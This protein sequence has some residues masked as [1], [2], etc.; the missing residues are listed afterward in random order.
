MSQTATSRVIGGRYRVEELLGAGGTASVYRA[1]DDSLGVYRALKMLH[2]DARRRGLDQR[3]ETE[4]RTMA[5]VHHPNILTIYDVG[6]E[7]GSL[8]I[9]TE[10]ASRGSL[11]DRVQRLGPLPP[12]LACACAVAIVD[13][14]DAAHRHGI[15]H[16]DVKPQNVLVTERG[17]VKLMDF[18]IAHVPDAATFGMTV[19][20]TR[21][22]TLAYMPPEQRVDPRRV[23]ARSDLY[24]AGA[25]LCVLLT[26]RNPAD[27][28]SLDAHD[29]LLDGVPKVIRDVIVRATRYRAVDRYA[30]AA[31]MRMALVAARDSLPADPAGAITLTTPLPEPTLATHAAATHAGTSATDDSEGMAT[32]GVQRFAAPTPALDRRRGGPVAAPLPFAAGPGRRQ[33]TADSGRVDAQPARNRGCQRGDG[34]RGQ[35][36]GA[37]GSDERRRHPRHAE[38]P[39]P[40]TCRRSR[41]APA[42]RAAARTPAG[43]GARRQRSA[44]RPRAESPPPADGAVVELTGDA[45]ALR[46]YDVSGAVRG[47]G[48]VPAGRYRVEADFPGQGTVAAGA[49][50]VEE[51]QR[52]QVDCLRGFFRCRPT[53]ISGP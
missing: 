19:T 8:F 52:V 4:A 26:R 5:R 51:G 20:G 10:Y 2:P 38:R 15:V 49:L 16:R 44:H 37:P 43:A 32:W 45:T 42:R 48:P 50:V 39:H 13:A 41:G 14:L 34:H 1:W 36:P 31:E 30:S 25:T 9:V 28:H 24:A 35:S 47:P 17:V 23:D 46:L 11:A 22:G 7:N 29:R 27:L 18:G 33:A 21:L 12:R 6:T 40:V 3:L 53:V